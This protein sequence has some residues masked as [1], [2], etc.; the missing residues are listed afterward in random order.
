MKSK[1]LFVRVLVILGVLIF[2]LFFIQ[3]VLFLVSFALVSLGG[4]GQTGRFLNVLILG[5]TF[6]AGS[7]LAGWIALRFH[8]L[9]A[10]PKYL[11]RAIGTLLGAFL[12]FL[13]ALLLSA[14]LGPGHTFYELSILFCI[15]GF[16]VPTWI[17][18]K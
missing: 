8:W 11:A 13:A 15:L 12:P 9:D 18:G 4:Y 5:L 16:Y 3:V 1:P 14:N 6:S 17:R 10:D 7:F 2:Q